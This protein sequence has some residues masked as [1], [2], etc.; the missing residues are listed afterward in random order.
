MREA[1]QEFTYC[2]ILFM[3]FKKT[4]SKTDLYC[5]TRDYVVKL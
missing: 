3:L 4:P 2:V 5:L 1:G